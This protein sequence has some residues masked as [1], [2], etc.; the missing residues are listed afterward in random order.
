MEQ[1]N[2]PLHGVKLQ[3]IVE[4][5][6]AEYGWEYLGNSIPVKCFTKDPSVKD[7]LISFAIT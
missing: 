7:K 1:T 5:L 4:E 6:Q 3:Q 2:N